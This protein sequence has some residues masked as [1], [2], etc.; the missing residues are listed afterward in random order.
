MKAEAEYPAVGRRISAPGVLAKELQRR[1]GHA[2]GRAQ[3]LSAGICRVCFG[4]WGLIG[5]LPHLLETSGAPFEDACVVFSCFFW[6]GE[7]WGKKDAKTQKEEPTCR[8]K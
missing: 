2:K 7:A 1:V 8:N 3:V 6:R 4:P 5:L